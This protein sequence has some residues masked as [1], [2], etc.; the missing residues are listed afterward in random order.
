MTSI[1]P[2]S[3]LFSQVALIPRRSFEAKLVVTKRIPARLK[4]KFKQYFVRGSVGFR[5]NRAEI[6]WVALMNE[7]VTRSTQAGYYVEFFWNHDRSALFLGLSVGYLQFRKLYGKRAVALEHLDMAV[8]ALSQMI[9][10]PQSRGFDRGF[11]DLG[12][13]GELAKGYEVSAVLHKSYPISALDD[14][15]LYTDLTRLLEIY[16]ELVAEGTEIMQ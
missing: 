16:D 1:T 9:T 15:E 5:N 10:R 4:T 3:Q 7:S 11:M 12:A 13:T 6:F 2:L 14:D 8:T